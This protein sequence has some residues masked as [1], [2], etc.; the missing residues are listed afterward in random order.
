MERACSGMPGLVR[1]PPADVQ[2]ADGLLVQ[3]E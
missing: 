1:N 2:F 3:D